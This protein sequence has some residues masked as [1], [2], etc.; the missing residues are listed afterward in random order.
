MMNSLIEL[1]R[2]FRSSEK[3]GPVTLRNELKNEFDN[4]LIYPKR[5]K[6]LAILKASALGIT[7][8][9][10]RFVAWICLKD[11]S[12]KG[13]QIIIIVGPRLELAVSLINR[14]KDL[15]K[16]GYDITF[17][18]K[19]TVINLNGTRIECFPS[20]HVDSARGLPNIS[21]IY[22][23]E[24]SFIPDREINNCMSILLRNIPKSNPFLIVSSTPNKPLDMMDQIMKEDPGTSI[25]KQIWL[26]W[27]WGIGKIY[28]KEEVD[29]IRNSRSFEREFNLKFA[30][31][32]GNVLSPVAIDRCIDLGEKLATTAPLDDWNI[33]TNYVMS[34]DI[35]WGSSNTA[36]MLSRFV[37]NKV[38]IIY[39]KEFARP[40]FQ[41]IINEIW[42]LK[43]KC[44]GNLQ[45]ILMDASATELYTSLC[46]E[47]NQ[48]PSQQYLRDKQA[49]CKKTN[50]YLENYLFVV[51]IPF[52]PAGKQ[53]LN[54]TQRMIS[55]TE[56]DGTAMVGIHPQ[57]NDLIYS[58]RSAY[59]VE[60]KIDKERGSFPDSFDSL[61]MNLSYYRWSK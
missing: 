48:N 59:A 22:V 35:G 26:D 55:E 38:Q 2:G 43:A 24:S 13:S 28:D 44:N 12:L 53:M 41:D 60:D 45:N 57:F 21:L 9:I 30:G 61:L 14:L 6:H 31:L 4:R 56:E 11:D 1:I 7:E 19:E 40:V 58:M 10:L 47:F 39:S 5:V 50:T 29:K 20:H 34:I 49:W 42:R 33:P 51:P 3:K 54:H 23:D 32:A 27:R 37:N 52:N 18:D 36:I 8:L 25:W 15:F 17:P 16:G 46:S